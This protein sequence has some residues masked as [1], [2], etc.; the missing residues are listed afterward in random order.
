MIPGIVRIGGLLLVV[1]LACQ[2]A[3]AQANVQAPCDDTTVALI[4]EHFA[5][6]KFERDNVDDPP[7]VIGARIVVEACRKW[8]AAPSRTIAAFLFDRRVDGEVD[9]LL[10]IVDTAAGRI[11]ASHRET[12]GLMANQRPSENSITIDTAHY[13]LS[14][15]TRAFALRL[16]LGGWG[17]NCAHSGG[18]GDE[19]TLY[20]VEGSVIRPVLAEA[21]SQR[22][23]IGS[24]CQPGGEL[25]I[26]NV[27]KTIAVEPTSS[28]GFADLRISAKRT[29]T[30]ITATS[31]S[32]VLCKDERPFVSAVVRYDG[33]R[34]ERKPWERAFDE[35]DMNLWFCSGVR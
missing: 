31:E 16:D 28:N 18:A 11:V 2:V 15:T 6:A 19:L 33:T 5:I 35:M 25:L 23:F 3:A 26:A 24:S 1:S 4:G 21:M 10:A 22:Y 34:Y 17:S 14:P 29:D 30:R 9:L 13:V 7:P 8:P 12:L 20:V 27:Q 32:M